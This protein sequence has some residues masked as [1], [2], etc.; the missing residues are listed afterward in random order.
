MPIALIAHVGDDAPH[1]PLVTAPGHRTF[2][3]IGRPAA[4]RRIDVV[5]CATADDAE[6]A[7]RR[8]ATP[9]ARPGVYELVESGRS[10]EEPTADAV[11]FVNCLSVP[12]GM[13]TVA[14]RRWKSINDYMIGRPGYLSF[15]FHRRSDAQ[16]AFAFVNI[17]Q[18][19]SAESFHA[20]RDAG[21]AALAADLPFDVAPTLC[22]PTGALAR[23]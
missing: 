14:Y 20:A 16:A 4:F 19:R 6:V 3:P 8:L 9:G 17:V 23:A 7:A 11:T 1:A 21:F 18:W 5:D 15:A 22:R 10:G 2:L 13:E 12:A